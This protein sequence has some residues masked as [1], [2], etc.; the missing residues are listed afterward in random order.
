MI[1]AIEHRI[2]PAGIQLRDDARQFRVMDMIDLARATL[3]MGGM[4]TQFMSKQEV[5]AKAMH[6][7]SDFP[8]ILW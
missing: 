5:A 1:N 3:Q 4:N 7:S 6:S 8:L 2:S